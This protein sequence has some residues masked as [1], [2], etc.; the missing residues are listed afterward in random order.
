M[1]KIGLQNQYNTVRH[2]LSM[3][4]GKY[5]M[6]QKVAVMGYGKNVPNYVSAL[7]AV[8]LRPVITLDPAEAA[9]CAGLLLPGGGDIDPARFGQTNAGSRDIDPYLDEVQLAA[10]DAFVRGEKPVLGICRGHQVVNIGLG[11][12]LVQDLPTADS[13]MAHGHTDSVHPAENLPGSVLYGLYG[14][15]MIVNSAHH[16]GL[17]AMGAGLRA[18]SFAPDGTVEA[19]EHERL[20][21]LTVQ[22]H[23]ERMAFRFARTDT[24][25]G[26]PIFAW[27]KS[28]L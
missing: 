11:G 14:A 22:F 2:I 17:G 4:T 8:G 7:E 13:H 20:P 28:K 1:S 16:Q 5:A 15:G 9:A 24:A 26:R 19:A 21:I 18:V 12:S 10:L 25:D 3:E 27:L 23:P 6:L